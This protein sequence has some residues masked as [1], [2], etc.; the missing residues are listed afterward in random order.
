MQ[1]FIAALFGAAA[2]LGLLYS[3]MT[4]WRVI[5]Q[6]ELDRFQAELIA[7]RLPVK[8]SGEWMFDPNYRTALERTKV[9]GV[10]ESSA[11]Y[12][13]RQAYENGHATSAPAPTLGDLATQYSAQSQTSQRHSSH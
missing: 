4:P 6:E 10:T 8:R 13:T 7:A 12:E 2:T 11:Q 1:F 9:G 5:K 3:E